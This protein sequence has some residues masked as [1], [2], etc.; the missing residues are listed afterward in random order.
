MTNYAPTNTGALTVEQLGKLVKGRAKQAARVI[1]TNLNVAPAGLLAAFPVDRLDSQ[2]IEMHTVQGNPGQL[3]Q[4]LDGMPDMTRHK[5]VRSYKDM[6]N[7]WDK[8]A[9]KIMDSAMTAAA[10]NRLADDGTRFI[11]NYFAACRVYKLLTELVAKSHASNTH[12]AGTAG[13]GSASYWGAAGTAD[14]EEDIAAAVTGIVSRT[15][16]AVEGGQYSIGVAYPSKV[17]DEFMQLDLINQVTQRLK[18]YLKAAW[19]V[20]L[21]PIT[22]YKDADGVEIIDVKTKIDSDALTTSAVVFF[23]GSQTMIGGEYRPSDIMLNETQREIGNGWTT[24]MKQCCEYLAVPTTGISNG[25]SALVYKI[26]G[27]TT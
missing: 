27:V 13:G 5:Y 16:A 18:D 9:Y 1:D 8:Q 11:Q 10:V 14:A 25:T 12:A 19:N 24:V 21:Y 23:E 20:N 6:T 15:G 2:M 7:S 26:T 17:L 22:P 3:N 4:A